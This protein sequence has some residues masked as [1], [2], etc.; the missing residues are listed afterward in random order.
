M[1]CSLPFV[2][3]LLWVTRIVLFLASGVTFAFDPDRG[4]ELLWRSGNASGYLALIECISP[5]GSDTRCRISGLS[6]AYVLVSFLEES[7]QIKP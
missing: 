4:R 1:K 6:K 5:I 7:R 3:T 2:D